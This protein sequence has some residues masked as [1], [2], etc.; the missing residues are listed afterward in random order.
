MR[1]P[2]LTFKRARALRR[3]MSLPEVV[4]WQELRGG[5]LSG[6]R[7]RRQHPIGPYILDF[8]CASARLAVEVDG[9]A[10]DFAERAQHDERRDAWLASRDIRVLRF[11]A[12][13]V[14]K[15]E[16]LE[17]ALSMIAAVAANSSPAERGRETAEDSGRGG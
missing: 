7:F 12:E 13:D 9:A 6:L 10:H 2:T 4:L 3:D 8:Y 16:R 1:A 17:G 5:R 15:D 14:L 11:T